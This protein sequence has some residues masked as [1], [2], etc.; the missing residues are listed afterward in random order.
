M[1]LPNLLPLL[2]NNGF[3]TLQQSS[4]ECYHSFCGQYEALGKNIDNLVH[5][6][7]AH[8]APY[9]ETGTHD[10]LTQSCEDLDETMMKRKQRKPNKDLSSLGK[11]NKIKA[12]RSP[13][14][15]KQRPAIWRRMLAYLT[16]CS[17]REKF[18]VNEFR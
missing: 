10:C 2:Q 5:S 17:I 13:E 16:S 12:D 4:L 18:L 7:C 8:W 9:L 6:V 1:H 14:S 3:W 15:T 11:C